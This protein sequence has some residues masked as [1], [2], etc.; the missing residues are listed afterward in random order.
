MMFSTLVLVCVVVVVL[1]ARYLLGGHRVPAGQPPL[2]ELTNDSMDSLKAEFNRSADG[3]R[4][5]LLLS[6]T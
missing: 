6:P 1:G 4:I 5:I 3:L 2:T